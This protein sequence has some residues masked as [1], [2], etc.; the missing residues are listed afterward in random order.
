MPSFYHEG[1]PPKPELK[2]IPTTRPISPKLGRSKTSRSS[3][4][5]LDESK[6]NGE[7][8]NMSDSKESAAGKK[9][10][11]KSLTK[12]PSQKSIMMRSS[13]KVDGS[14][15][16]IQNA[17]EKANSKRRTDSLKVSASKSGVDSSSSGTNKE[18]QKQNK[19]EAGKDDVDIQ[20]SA[21][22][23]NSELNTEN[24][25]GLLVSCENLQA[26]KEANSNVDDNG[27]LCDANASNELELVKNKEMVF[28]QA[29]N[30]P[31]A[32]LSN[33]DDSMDA[34]RI[35]VSAAVTNVV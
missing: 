2:K 3:R 10:L 23:D 9:V 5:S 33:F 15:R 28:E 32:H 12:L 17:S 26:P 4:F 30:R 7:Q 16:G 22:C 29:Q 8:Q 35:D 24:A 20:A 19:F 14:E 13:E 6:L 21:K 25:S 31:I 18:N 34:S 27:T 1:A 11:R